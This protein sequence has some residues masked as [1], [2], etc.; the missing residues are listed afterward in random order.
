[1]TLASIVARFDI[2]FVEWTNLDG[3]KTDR[4]AANDA[5]YMG[6]AVMPPD[7]DMRIRWKRLW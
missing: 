7:K 5:R 6:T 3:T 1:M 2:E 4:A